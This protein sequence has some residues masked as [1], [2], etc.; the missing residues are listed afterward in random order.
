MAEAVAS[1]TVLADS[2]EKTR[3]QFQTYLMTDANAG[4][5]S[6]SQIEAK[7]R[8]RHMKFPSLRGRH[9]VDSF[10]TELQDPG[11]KRWNDDGDHHAN[12]PFRSYDN[13]IDPVSGFVS[14]GGDVDRNAGHDR[15]CSLVQLNRTPQSAA[16]RDHNSV[17][18]SEPA[19]PPE[20]KRDHTWVP[21]GPTAWNSRKTSDAWIKSQLGGWTSDYDP[22][23]PAPELTRSKSMYVPKPPSEESKSS[24]DHLALQYMYG[25]STQRSYC[26]VP[27]DTMLAPKCWAPTGT[28]ED[29]PDMISHRWS[30]K[31]YDP[32]AQ[33]WQSTGR[34]WDW[35]QRRRGYYRTEPINF[36]SPCPRVQ[37]IPLY[38]GCIGAENLEEI[39]NQREAF[40]PYT[41]KRVP[42]PR[43]SETAHRPNIPGYEGCT[44]W[45]GRYAPAN[46]QP[47]P[48]PPTQPTTSL[49][50]KSFPLPQDSGRRRGAE[51]S[52]MV[53][54]VPPCN[55]FNSMDKEEVVT[56]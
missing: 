55:P 23:K 18:T 16:P 41:V 56:A 9:D 12:A 31:K 20:L 53:T 3:P 54:L 21:G 1:R 10:Q 47:P 17:R 4:G 42:I 37:Q 27:W 28:S 43:P 50:H 45:Q 35:F 25:A 40:Q 36:S 5:H 32:A 14:A 30:N 48:Q 26:E 52:R 8:I 15:I 22:R 29:K 7:R 34:S 38:G 49:I 46:T 51:M 11:F 24:R 39:D 2:N 33:E 44:L 6:V 19:A 13:I